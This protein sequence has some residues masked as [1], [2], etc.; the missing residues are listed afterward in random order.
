M[1]FQLEDDAVLV[2]FGLFIASAILLGLS[3]TAIAY[4]ISLLVSEKSK[5]VGFALITWFFVCLSI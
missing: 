2:T 1:F 3:F 5:A 4:L